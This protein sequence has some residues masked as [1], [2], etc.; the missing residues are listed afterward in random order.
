MFFGHS[1]TI[2]GLRVPLVKMGIQGPF[3]IQIVQFSLKNIFTTNKFEVNP[4]FCSRMIFFPFALD[5]LPPQSL[6]GYGLSWFP[7]SCQGQL[8]Q[9]KVITGL[10]RLRTVLL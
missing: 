8:G 1:D 3:M 7:C 5:H 4:T 6:F 9:L 10:S 2:L